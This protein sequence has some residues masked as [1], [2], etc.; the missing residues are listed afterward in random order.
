MCKIVNMPTTLE[1]SSCSTDS[2]RRT[3]SILRI[4]STDN[5]VSSS[6]PSTL[7]DDSSSHSSCSTS[8]SYP[9]SPSNSVRFHNVQIREYG[10]VLGDNPSCSKGLPISL[11]WDYD[12]EGE[13]EMLLDDF[14]Q[15]R[16]G[17]RRSMSQMKIPACV[18]FNTLRSW[19]VQMK[20]MKI[21]ESEL[22]QIRNQR[23]RT[24][25]KLQ[26]KETMKQFTQKLKRTVSFRRLSDL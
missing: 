23:L 26:R 10:I 24:L 1:C 5:I 21:I 8:S 16:G 7:D 14:E 9:L 18:R 20:D 12:Q 25:M 11:S 13:Q 22:K 6:A 19:D 2:V 3:K 4:K 15:W 17:Q